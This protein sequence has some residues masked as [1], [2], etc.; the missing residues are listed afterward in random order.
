MAEDE[1]NSYLVYAMVRDADGNKL[2]DSYDDF[3]EDVTFEFFD[4]CKYYLLCYE[5]NLSPNWEEELPEAKALIKVEELRSA[6]KEK[7]K[8]LEKELETD[9]KKPPTRKTKKTTTKKAPA[10]RAP[11]KSPAAKKPTKKVVENKT[12]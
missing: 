11:R 5:Y 4:R 6:A 12:E 2:A 1:R 7:Q 9:K 3:L 8:E 10:K